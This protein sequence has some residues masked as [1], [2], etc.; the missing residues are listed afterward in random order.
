MNSFTHTKKAWKAFYK[1]NRY[2][3]RMMDRKLAPRV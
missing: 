3:P 1:V 2:Y